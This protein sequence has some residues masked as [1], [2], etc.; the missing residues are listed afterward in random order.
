[1]FPFYQWS[2]YFIIT[3]LR[4][5]KYNLFSVFASTKIFHSKNILKVVSVLSP[6]IC[7]V[8]TAFLPLFL[9]VPNKWEMP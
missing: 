9:K 6:S 3:E 2:I 1:M 5:A 8:R 4:T 7:M